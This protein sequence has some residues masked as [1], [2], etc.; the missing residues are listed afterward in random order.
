MKFATATVSADEWT[1]ATWNPVRGC[2]KIS[3]G[4]KHCYAE[5]FAER[6]R[7]VAG[8]PY[9]RGFDPR[10]VP[11]SL[12]APLRWT[13]PRLVFVNSMSD[14]FF[15]GFEDA[16]IDAVFGVMASAPRHTFQVLTKRADRL[17][18]YFAALQNRVARRAEHLADYGYAWHDYLAE[19]AK[20][21]GVDWT[22][23]R[24]SMSEAIARSWP[25]PNLHLGVSVEDHRVA[26]RVDDLRA[27][28]ASLRWLSVEPL[29]GPL[30][31]HDRLGGIEEP[32]PCGLRD[33]VG[34]AGLVE[35]EITLPERLPRGAVGGSKRPDLDAHGV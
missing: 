11:G 19:A 25:L 16:Y 26:G 1:D 30:D 3:A 22:R 12:D 14:L 24:L 32:A 23:L 35:G 28:P 31:L 34:D 10:T 33:F 9:E 18:R 27:A 5:T 13:R 21:A 4:C 2:V 15:D 8:H 20:A 7:G 6:W 17:P 29:I